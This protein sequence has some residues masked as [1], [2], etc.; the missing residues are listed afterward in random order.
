MPEG[1][2]YADLACG[3]GGF[4][5]AAHVAGGHRR[6]ACDTDPGVVRAFNAAHGGDGGA[7]AVREPIGARERWPHLA[8]VDVVLAG[9]PCQAF[10]TI[11]ARRGFDDARGTVIFDLFEMAAVLRPVALVL[12]CVW[13]FFQNEEWLHPTLRAFREIGYGAVVRREEAGDY[14]PQDRERGMLVLA[15]GD[16]WPHVVGG[17]AP[18]FLGPSPKRHASQIGRAHV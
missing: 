10:S 4:T 18:L 9:F 1:W 11:G 14:L 3:I 16:V 13:G 12:E 17:L 15:R 8:G 2:T 5:V 7:L 6:W